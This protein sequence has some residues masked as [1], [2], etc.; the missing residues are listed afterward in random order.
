[1]T[2][3]LRD[4]SNHVVVITG[5]TTGIGEAT[6]RQLVELG[7]K[8]ALNARN[9]EKLEALVGELGSENSIFVA[10]DTAN[11]VVMRE[12]VAA[13]IA[14]WGRIDAVVPNAGIGKYGS[15]LDWSD[16]EVNEMMRTNYEGTVHAVR[17]AVP[18]FI[19]QK[20]GDVVIVSSV[21]GF[22][23]GAD[24]SIYAGTKHAQVGFAGGLDRELQPHGIRTTL[25][26]PAGTATEFAIGAGRTQGSPVL[27]T[28][29]RP[30]DVAF[31]V[32]MVLRQP[33]SV[34]TGV[35][36]LWSAQQPS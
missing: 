35:W 24:E 28:F 31:Q 33:R 8:V 6:A 23:G 5:A 21:A 12:L 22:R 14:K 9:A 4:L 36:T 15:V 10:G 32:V 17:A 19:A 7:A 26:C 29:L 2:Y 18:H 1:M 25:I 30:D 27:D 11:P 34:R 16:D 3:Q 13:A 20:S